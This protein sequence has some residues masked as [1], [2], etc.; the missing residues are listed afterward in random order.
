MLKDSSD[1]LVKNKGIINSVLNGICRRHCMASAG[2]C[3]SEAREFEESCQ[4]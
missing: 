4:L 3:T 2:M 1:S